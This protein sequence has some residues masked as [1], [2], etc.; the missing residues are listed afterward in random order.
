MEAMNRDECTLAKKLLDR[1]GIEW[2]QEST[3]GGRF[4]LVVF[5]SYVDALLFYSLQQVVEVYL[6]KLALGG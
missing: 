3:D 6:A 2:S 5:A 1:V 4:V